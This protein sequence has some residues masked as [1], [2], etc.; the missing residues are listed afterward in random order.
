M[1]TSSYAH[2]PVNKPYIYTTIPQR[3]ELQ[4]QLNG[5][6]EVYVF[7]DRD[8][9]RTS[10]TTKELHEMSNKYAKAL[11]QLGIRQGDVVALCLLNDLDGLLWLFSVIKAGGIV[12]T[13]NTTK[14]DGS[15]VRAVLSRAGAKA[16][17]IHPG[18]LNSIYKACMNVVNK[19]DEDGNATSD[20]VPT[21]KYFLSVQS[22]SGEKLLTAENM[23]NKF[24][25]DE[26]D[27]PR[28]DPDDT[29]HMFLSSGS[30]GE[31]KM[32]PVTHFKT[33]IAC[34]HMQDIVQYDP[35]DIIYTE[36][37]LAWGAGF[38]YTV[39]HDAPTV[40]T[41]TTAIPS[42]ADHCRFTLDAIINE[43]C[44]IACLFPAT[45][46]GL[47]DLLSGRSGPPL[48]KRVNMGGLPITS[49]CYSGIG[50]LA[51]VITNV[52][53]STEA[54]G[55]SALHVA[56]L[57]GNLDYNTGQPL[58]GVEVKVVNDKGFVVDRGEKGAI[59]VRTPTMFYGYPGNEEKTKAVLSASR[60]FNSDDTGYMDED[61]NLIVSGR[62]SDII[63]QGG[64]I[65]SSTAVEAFIK[66]NPDVADA[67]VVPVPDDVYFQLVCACVIP[68]SGSNLTADDIRNFYE[69]KYLAS[70][71]EAFSG[72]MPKMV[73]IFD[74]YPRLYTDKPD[75]KK[76]IA[77]AIGRKNETENTTSV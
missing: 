68:K 12:M 46:V 50:K 66:T 64:K 44:N 7:L 40:V 5:D 71:S 35:N 53:G 24:F 30:T 9:T 41:K 8:G 67:V 28:L 23:L 34:R 3:L 47:T 19:F 37:R 54:G 69:T 49:I 52:Y 76:L 65:I 31:P 15:D 17:I 55:I 29:S 39:L 74:E 70:A 42:M 10:I 26:T 62:Q 4:A 63:L 60:W 6:K 21:L 16:L 13:V 14:E 22:V 72:F 73:L 77:I 1:E 32:I 75:K 43:K 27:L 20:G 18:T 11:V 45:I 36:R 38:P 57:K 51:S 61:G 48:L 56:K 25:S 59:Y 2:T 33:M 58:P